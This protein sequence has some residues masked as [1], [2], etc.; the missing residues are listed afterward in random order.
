MD[1]PFAYKGSAKHEFRYPPRA[2]KPMVLLQDHYG[3]SGVPFTLN[4]IANLPSNVSPAGWVS[5][6][7]LGARDGGL[8]AKPW[9]P[10]K[11][12]PP[13]RE[14]FNTT[15]ARSTLEV[16]PTV[17]FDAGV[18]I[19]YTP[20]NPTALFPALAGVA[21]LEIEVV[22]N[23]SFKANFAS[24]FGV[25]VREGILTGACGTHEVAGTCGFTEAALLSEVNSM[26]RIGIDGYVRVKVD[27]FVNPPFV[28][29]FE[30][31]KSFAAITLDEDRD[32]NS[33]QPDAK[34]VTAA[35]GIFAWAGH[36]ASTA[37]DKPIWQGARGYSGM[38]AGR[39]RVVDASVFQDEEGAAGTA[40]AEARPGRCW[41]SDAGLAAL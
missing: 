6:V 14:D 18:P 33:M 12:K 19:K 15:S 39:P 25:L 8:N 21:N 30:V 11:Q 35:H 5:Q 26:G 22:V 13:V 16:T 2:E 4:A 9:S 20:P 23:P 29:D 3:R 32:W 38:K 10:P 17:S 34:D 41:R 27:L 40:D 31:K 28:D 36:A 7:G 24:Q 37:P 1:T